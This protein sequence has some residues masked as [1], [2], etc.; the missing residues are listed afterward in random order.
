MKKIKVFSVVLVAVMLF[1]ALAGCA[2]PKPR[3]MKEGVV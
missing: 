3:V 1:S 2:Q